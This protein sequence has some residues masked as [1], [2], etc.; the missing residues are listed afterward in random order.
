MDRFSK[1]QVKIA[2]TVFDCDGDVVLMPEKDYTYEVRPSPF[3][4][5]CPQALEVELFA[6]A[7]IK[8]INNLYV[9]IRNEDEVGELL[10]GIEW[11]IEAKLCSYITQ[12]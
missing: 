12:Q 5:D 4:H 6:A 11:R 1:V 3:Y 7:Q 8:F 10:D 2:V 9:R